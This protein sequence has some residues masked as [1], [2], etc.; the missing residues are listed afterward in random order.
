MARSQVK[1]QSERV[2][3]DVYLGIAIAGVN[4]L[5]ALGLIIVFT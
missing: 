4:N 1:L 5:I 3:T 2:M